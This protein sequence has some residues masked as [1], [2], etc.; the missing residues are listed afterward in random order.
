MTI[1]ASNET[2]IVTT[3][4]SFSGPYKGIMSGAPYFATYV[5]DLEQEPFDA[6]DLVE[7]IAWRM[8][9][10]AETITDP[11]SLKNKFEEE[12]GG[13]Q[14]LCD[15]FQNRVSTLER[16]LNEEKREYTQKLQRLH[17]KNSEA[18]D[19]MK[20]LKD[21]MQNVS[22]KVVYLGDQLESVDQ[23]RSRAHDAFQLMQHFDE[24]LS[25]QPLNSM[26]F[27]DPDKLLESADLV[28]KLYSISQELN[29]EKFAAVQARIAQRYQVV[30]RLL[31][32]EF[33]RSQRDE[34]K[35]AEVAKV[36]SEFKG[37]SH[38]V[39]R[40]VEFLCATVHPRNDGDILADCLHLCR[41]QQPR[42]TAIFPS[43]HTVMQKL[44][45]NLF[46]GKMKEHIYAKL[47]DCKESEDHEQYLKD[48]AASYSSTLKM[49][50]ELEKLHV[51]PDSAFLAT[52]TK[53]IFDRFGK[54][55]FEIFL[56]FV[57]KGTFSTYCKEE[58]SYLNQ[59]CGHILAKF[60]ESKKHVKKQI[61]GGLQELKRDVAARLMNVE[62]YGGETFLS[63]D[64]AISVLQETKNA[65]NRAA[66][67]CEPEELPQHV[68]NVVDV[69]LK[70][71]YSEHLDYAVETGLAGISLAEPKTEPPP[72][73]FAVVSQCTTIVLLLVKQYDDSIFPIIKNSIVEQMV[74]KKWQQSLRSLEQKMNLGLER[75]LNS[76]VGYSRY[77]LSEQKKADFRPESQ[78]IDLGI[79]QQCKM[80]GRFLSI[81]MNHMERGCDGENIETLQADLATRLY[82]V[83]LAHI[84]QFSYNSAGAMNLMCDVRE[85]RNI[86]C[87]WS[88]GEAAAQWESLLAL[89]NLLVVLPDNLTDAAQSPLLSNVDRALIQDFI[90]LRVDFKNLKNVRAY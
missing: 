58:L 27:T 11:E 74:A 37:Y 81:Q 78:Q 86:V 59:Q 82:K 13:L 39:D 36:L 31:I 32:D 66:Q 22:T 88:V 38:C 60:Y 87:S 53:S 33:A 63:E 79:S 70:Y 51:S 72:Y 61:G 35:M 67:L 9:G 23:P 46:T 25:D 68:E 75:Q 80:V 14:M 45:L 56:T 12:I 73:F 7:R 6:M 55:K 90:K 26:I 28:Q 84:Q 62:T 50:T 41:T 15:Q 71:L 10:G 65:F 76:I 16:Q 18:I 49:C 42:I 2:P 54:N 24:F 85:L 89:T 77:L 4:A 83:M 52:L 21:T 69:L 5:E 8:T 43:P 30:E 20:K 44:V 1:G 17:E 40:Y 34:K 29:K 57:V 64:V 3:F 19:K 48:L 47:R